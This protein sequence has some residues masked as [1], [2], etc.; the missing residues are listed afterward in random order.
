MPVF[1]TFMTYDHCGILKFHGGRSC[2]QRAARR[3]GITSRISHDYKDMQDMVE[4][5]K[6]DIS[7]AFL[8]RFL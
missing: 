8:A 5:V 7:G 6:L 1:V 4:N 3:Q 2:L